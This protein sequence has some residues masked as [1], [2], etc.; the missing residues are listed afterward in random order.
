MYLLETCI[1]VSAFTIETETD[2]V[3]SWLEAHRDGPLLVNDWTWV[4]FASAV[5]LKQRKGV[6]TG[7]QHQA[8]LS[9]ALEQQDRFGLLQV[10]RD[11][12]HLTRRL[13]QKTTLG[14]RAGDAQHVAVAPLYQ[15]TLVTSDKALRAANGV[16][17]L[18]CEAP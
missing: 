13:S 7:Q 10:E 12:F 17:G 5:T 11:H 14:I 15:V 4:E 2:K 16:Y 8:V 1:L 3:L 18:S 9:A 6:L